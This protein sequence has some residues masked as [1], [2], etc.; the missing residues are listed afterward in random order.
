MA[1]PEYVCPQCRLSVARLHD[2]WR[3]FNCSRHFPILLGIPDFRLRG[4]AY[5]SL[6]EERAKAERL[7]AFGRSAGFAAMV[8]H[9]YSITDDVPPASVPVFAGY[10]HDG[11]GRARAALDRLAEDGGIAVLLD[12]G[13][14]SGGALVASHGRC[15]QAVGVDVALRW[16]VIARKRLDEAGID[17]PLICANAEA[18]PFSPGTFTH[19]LA[20][21]VIDNVDQPDAM[22][23]QVAAVLAPGGRL[24][25]SAT[26][27]RWVGPHPATGIWAAGLVP[28][29]WRGARQQRRRG[30]DP[31]RAVRLHSPRGLERLAARA[32]LRTVSLRPRH[33]AMAN[34]TGRPPAIRTL[35][36]MY[37]L[38]ARTPFVRSLLAAFGP[39]VE[40]ILVSRG[41]VSGG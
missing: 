24:W 36:R 40:M 27:R 37:G 15:A 9:Y 10:V 31:L 35:A 13:C 7:Q 28:A 21:D 12:L 18:L 26:N 6:E 25:L 16:L 1:D 34:M 20:D 14:G 11:P 41:F 3:C 38:A 30:Y 4:D 29:R 19:C 23:R 32:G 5:L 22:L 17:A 33:V 2:G 8:D 39:A